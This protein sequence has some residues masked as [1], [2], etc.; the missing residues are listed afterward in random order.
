MT[1]LKQMIPG[2][3]AQDRHPQ[4]LKELCDQRRRELKDDR[5]V[6]EFVLPCG[7]EGAAIGPP[8]S[9]WFALLA[10]FPEM[11]LNAILASSVMLRTNQSDLSVSGKAEPKVVSSSLK[12]WMLLR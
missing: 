1:Q 5:V 11:F 4:T 12:L 2:S 3:A 9:G 10:D 8:V 6:V 7:Q